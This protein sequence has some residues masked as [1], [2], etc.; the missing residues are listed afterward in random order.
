MEKKKKLGQYMTTNYNYIFSDLNIP[1]KI[2]KIIEPFCGNGD[3]LNFI[4]KSKY[5]IQCF[6]IEPTKKYI[7][8][9]D[10]LLNPPDFSNSF[11]ITNPP[12][13][14][15]N[16]NNDKTVYN[17]YKVNDLYKCHI[18]E[19]ITNNPIGG[20]MI[21]PLNF[22][23]SI[24]EIDISL[25]KQFL[26]IYK[27]KKLNIFEEKVFDDTKYTICSFQYEYN[28]DTI[29]YIPTTIYPSKKKIKI[30]LNNENNYTIGGEI[31]SI[32]KSDK[33]KI[34]RLLEGETHNTNILLK[35]ID[36]NEK[37]KIKLKYISNDEIYYGKKT[38]R[39]YAVLS[40]EPNIDKKMQLKI[41]DEF[42][43]YINEKR[44]KYD[45]L[46]LTNYRESNNIARKRISFD[47][48]YKIVGML[49]NKSS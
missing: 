29:N 2:T 45:S 14:A 38:S 11:I 35:A 13:L 19:L 18:K 49:L 4:D 34:T 15:R 30:L 23:C 8:K 5:E 40:I 43:K 41:I 1:E 32:K 17:V 6:D 44:N 24:R 7:I 25:R 16:K 12:F 46:F 37:S 28:P 47:L 48:T 26:S 3:L 10:T 27:I 39:S 20:I 36:D 22:F 31:Y 33:Y 9:R 21:V 42:N